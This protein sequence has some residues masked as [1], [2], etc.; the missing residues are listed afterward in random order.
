MCEQIINIYLVKV[1][2]L[3]EN[4]PGS[5]LN[6]VTLVSYYQPLIVTSQQ[7]RTGFRPAYQQLS[8]SLTLQPDA[9]SSGDVTLS[10]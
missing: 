6:I 3:S 10:Q 1:S 8:T 7:G 4:H 2:N 5:K 9:T